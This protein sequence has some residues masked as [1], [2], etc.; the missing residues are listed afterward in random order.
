MPQDISIPKVENVSQVEKVSSQE[1]R[2]I[3]TS[4]ETAPE[5]SRERAGE[6]YSEILSMVAPQPATQ[7]VA[8]DDDQDIGI[9][10]DSVVR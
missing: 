6:R 9:D 3:P 1:Y 4:T 10:A 7:T 5:Q 2:R 8:R